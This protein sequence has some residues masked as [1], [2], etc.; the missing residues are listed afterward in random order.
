[1]SVEEIKSPMYATGIGLVIKALHAMNAG[2]QVQP[3]ETKQAK[4]QPRSLGL[5]DKILQK[6]KNWLEN[7]IEDSDYLR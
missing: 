3:T 1:S 6:G 5:F 2:R 7:D 4:Q